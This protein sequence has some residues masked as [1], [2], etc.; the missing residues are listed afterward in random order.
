MCVWGERRGKPQRSASALCSAA[1][2][3]CVRA[4]LACAP[5]AGAPPSGHTRSHGHLER[6][7]RR[8]E[9]AHERKG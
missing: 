1:T 4:P 6:E 9:R 2:A 8:E 7:R 5:T 3:G